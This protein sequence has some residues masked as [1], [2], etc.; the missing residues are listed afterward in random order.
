MRE[1]DVKVALV[2]PAESHLTSKRIFLWIA[3]DLGKVK[4]LLKPEAESV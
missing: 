3:R 1:E 4:Q 2:P